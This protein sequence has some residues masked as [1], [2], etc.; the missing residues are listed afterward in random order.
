[1]EVP[2]NCT[3]CEFFKS[4]QT[5]Y[6]SPACEYNKEIVQNQAK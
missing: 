1:M 2:N 4:C 5:C 6:G 3:E